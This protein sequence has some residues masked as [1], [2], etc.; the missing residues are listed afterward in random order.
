M[1]RTPG[2]QL[3]VPQDTTPEQLET[4]LNG[5]LNEDAQ[6]LPYLFYVQDR[7]L[8]E[9]LGQHL[10]QHQVTRGDACSVMLPASCSY[11]LSPVQVSVET[12]LAV[13][14]QPQAVFRVRPVTRC[15]ASLSGARRTARTAAGRC[16]ACSLHR[17]SCRSRRGRAVRE[18]QP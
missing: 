7:P 11:C 2:P 18:L 16:C 17:P 10:L 15:T 13:V 12:A 4:L 5:L 6:R 8:G 3:A 9:S 14:Y 1:T